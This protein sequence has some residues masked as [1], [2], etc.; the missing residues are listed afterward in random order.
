M[1]K[2]GSIF[3]DDIW[4]HVAIILMLVIPSAFSGI[5]IANRNF[6]YYLI[7]LVLRNGFMI[8]AAYLNAYYLIP[9]LLKRGQKKKF[10]IILTAIV[11]GFIAYC[12]VLDFIEV[13]YLDIGRNV[14]HNFWLQTQF[15]FF[16]ISRY[17]VIGFL[18]QTLKERGEQ[19]RIIDQISIEKLKAEIDHLKSQINPHFLFNT[20]NNIYGLT[21]E[22]SEKAPEI[23]LKLSKMMD[24]MLYESNEMYVY[25]KKDIENIKDYVDIERIRNGNKAEITL[26]VTGELE[27]QKIVPLLILP[28]IENAFTHGLSEMVEGGFIR[29]FILVGNNKLELKIHNNYQTEITEKPS[30]HGLGLVNLKKRLKLFYPGAHELVVEDNP[31][32]YFVTLRLGLIY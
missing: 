23:V 15:Y 24:Y 19:K 13:Q 20:L 22:K 11:I 1:E 17:V 6:P 26:E 14:F 3:K 18:L 25:L 5:Y 8:Y 4:I 27:N 32:L 21:L 2:K 7:N 31:P 16:N 28:L 10:W 12:M 30:G 9:K 29:I